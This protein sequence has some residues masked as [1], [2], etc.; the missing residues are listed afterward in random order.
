[1][2]YSHNPRVLFVALLLAL[3]AWGTAEPNNA[4]SVGSA[5]T[6][7]VDAPKIVERVPVAIFDFE[8]KA[9][10]N[11]D[12]GQQL[13]EILTARLSV[14]DQFTLV[15]RKRLQ[16]VLAELRLNLSGLAETS[17][18]AQV[19]RLIGA[20]ILVF[21]R[22]FAVDR[23][24]YIVARIVGTETSQVKAV[25]AKGKLESDLS[26]VIDQ[27]AEKL[28]GGLEQWIPQ[29]LPKGEKLETALKKLRRRLEGKALPTVA[30]I[31][32]ELQARGRSSDPAAATEIKKVFREAGFQVIEGDKASLEKWTQNVTLAG[33][34]L[35][36]TGEGFSEFGGQFGGLISC[37]ARLEVQA[38][39]RDS[40]QIIAVERTTRRAVD[41]SETIAA[42]TAFQSAGHELALRLAAQIARGLPP[43]KAGQEGS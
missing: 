17:Q 27:L 34:D 41:L 31:V 13:G 29:L 19:G 24:L 12:L 38:L 43:A 10:G 36:I 15:E 8:C 9:P 18:S 42:K 40:G 16:D 25:I 6:G 1:M 4:T 22:A 3:P 23:D 2:M 7:P 39:R 35:V 37:S 32:S 21:G 30:V 20:R 11:P 28:T 14:Q 33:S 5:P 26:L